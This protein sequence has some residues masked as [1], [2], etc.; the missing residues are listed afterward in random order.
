M[1]TLIRLTLSP[2]MQLCNLVMNLEIIIFFNHSS[3]PLGHAFCDGND[4]LVLVLFSKGFGYIF[5]SEM[6]KLRAGKIF[7]PS[8]L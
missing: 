7:Y 2:D 5:K 1:I 6:M 8:D 3:I 4:F